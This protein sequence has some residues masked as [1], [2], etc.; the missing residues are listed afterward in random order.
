MEFFKAEHLIGCA[1]V[2]GGFFVRVIVLVSPDCK[3][4]AEQEAVAKE[5]ER[6]K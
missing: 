2:E 4:V 3:G 6:E 5:Y 1:D